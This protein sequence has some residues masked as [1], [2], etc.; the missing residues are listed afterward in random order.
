M[1][2][3]QICALCGGWHRKVDAFILLDARVYDLLAVMPEAFSEHF[4]RGEPMT[5]P[6]R[7]SAPPPA[8][9]AT[10]PARA[11]EA[12]QQER[13]KE[14]IE[15]FKQLVRQ[16]PQPDWKAGLI[17]AYC[18][19]ARALAAKGMY[20][21]AAMVLENTLAPNGTLRDPLLYVTCLIRE[22]QQPKA[23]A[24]L[25]NYI[26]NEASQ[27]NE[28]QALEDLTA[29]LL[30]VATP[31]P[32]PVTAVS[33]EKARWRDLAAASREALAAWVGGASAEQIDQQL[34]R[35]SLRSAFRPLR[36][37]LK[38]LITLPPDAE[39]TA[40]L[41]GT[42]TPASPFFAFRQAVEAALATEMAI[43]RDADTWHRL[44]PAQQ[45]F[46]AETGGLSA[47]AAQGVTR[48]AEASRAGPAML[49]AYLQKQTDLPKQDVRSACLN[50]LPQLPDRLPQFEKSFGPLS[51]LERSRV[52]ALAAEASADWGRAEQ[53]WCR[54]A[55]ALAE[56]SDDRTSKL[57]QGVIYRH[58]AHLAT[59]YPAIEGDGAFGEATIFYLERS[60]EVDPDHIPT[61]LER[62]TYYR[63]ASREKEW[64]RLA[65]EAVQRF[66]E[67]SQILL[68]ATQSAVAREAYKKAASFAHRL[69]KIDPINPG[70]RR[71]MIELQVAHARK[72]MR[73]KRLDLAAKELSEAAKWERA[74]APSAVLRIARG[75]VALQADTKQSSA[76]EQGKVWLREG[77]ERAGGGVAGWFRAVLEAELMGCADG[78][79][80]SLRKE[81]LHARQTPPTKDAVTTVIS[82]LSQPESV[83]N[84]RKLA[85][86]VSS[87]RGWLSQGASLAWTAT[88]FQ[89]LSETLIRFNAF[90]VLGDYARAGRQ[91]DANNQEWRFQE[92]IART[93]NNPHAITGDE[94]DDLYEM[95]DAA[96]DRQD[97]HAAQRY[98]RFLET[99]DDTPDGPES[100]DDLKEGFGLDALQAMLEAMMNSMPKEHAKEIR[101]LVGD[102]GREAA[103]NSL[104]EE[105]SQSRNASGI[106]KPLIRMLCEA[107]VTKVMD[108]GKS[109]KSPF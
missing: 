84:A 22:G 6:Q 47:P 3:Q 52:Q 85:E 104:V 10:L 14:A 77:V 44:T 106:P 78:Q 43:G 72:Q 71:Q 76:T 33:A 32:A 108:N 91:R 60:C 13:F 81:L 55:S 51:K 88:E 15:L 11:A 102:F 49:F 12:L 45:A 79:K 86:L 2:Q 82:A 65:D 58:L 41:L 26:G 54:T 31:P 99:A 92:I 95:T 7:R 87:I 27:A 39:R 46:V 20:K 56:E 100:L 94:E 93:R 8:S 25:L 1:R 73:A 107:M 50:L 18:G 40:K 24:H 5:K 61:V 30:V 75:L 53:A 96:F 74:D 67:D 35:I 23:A 103:I 64:H 57:S 59:K 80:V 98:R 70:V 38:S 89:T 69:L 16:D 83:K 68:Q 66:P 63:K 37:L 28:H 101:K 48:L 21:E 105:H 29:A 19:R 90:D 9:I 97:I 36:L 62:I 42:I 17:E 34:N 4:W 109:G